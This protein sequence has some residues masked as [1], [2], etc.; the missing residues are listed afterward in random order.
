M[1]AMSSALA[2][3]SMATTAS[4][5]SSE[6]IGPTMWTPRISSV[7]ASARNF[8]MPVVS[9]SARARPFA[10]NGKVPAL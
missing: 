10:M 6:A 5:M 4:E 7:F 8:T 9:P 3:N 1:R 2:L